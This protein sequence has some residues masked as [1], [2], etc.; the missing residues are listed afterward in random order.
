MKKICFFLMAFVC[1]TATNSLA[2]QGDFGFGVK[3]GTLGIGGEIRSGIFEDL[4]MRAGYNVLVFDVEASSTFVDYKL[5]ADFHNG[6]FLMDWHPFSG[7]FRVTFG[8]HFPNTNE[9][10]VNGTPR[11]ENFTSEYAVFA[12]VA[13]DVKVRGTVS[14]TQAAPYFG[15]GWS[16]NASQRGWGVAFDV[17]ILMQ[18]PPEVE[19]LRV[20]SSVY[21]QEELDQ[22]QD[23]IRAINAFLEN[24]TAFIEDDLDSFQ[25]YPVISLTVCYNF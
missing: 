13:E 22:F 9:F 21:T 6:A 2:A 12:P 11:V 20:I 23:E 24:E 5:D 7:V 18:G 19:N 3:G 17:G 14:F 8:F 10:T 4:Y 1:L 16:S 15:L 25:Y